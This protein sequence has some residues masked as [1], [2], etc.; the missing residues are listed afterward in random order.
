MIARLGVRARIPQALESHVVA[1]HYV[2]GLFASSASDALVLIWVVH[3][4]LVEV[5]A[6]FECFLSSTMSCTSVYA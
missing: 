3:I 1:T 4:P 5:A 6:A 2:F